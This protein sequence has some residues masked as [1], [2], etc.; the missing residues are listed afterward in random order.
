MHITYRRKFK[1][2]PVQLKPEA[3]YH[4]GYKTRSPEGG[5]LA[6]GW[7]FHDVRMEP[8]LVSL[9]IGRKGTHTADWAVRALSLAGS[10]LTSRKIHPEAGYPPSGE[11][12]LYP[13]NNSFSCQMWSYKEKH[14]YW[15]CVKLCREKYFFWLETACSK[16]IARFDLFYP[17]YKNLLTKTCQN[18]R[19][20]C[21]VTYIYFLQSHCKIY[22]HIT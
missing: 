22:I 1:K 2:S 6:S 3:R 12:V 4:S 21:G 9:F 8:V 16:V 20:S 15:I 7:I 18:T 14:F 11:R 5:Y 19:Q 13:A 17:S 10:I